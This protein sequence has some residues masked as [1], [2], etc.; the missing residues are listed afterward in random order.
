M[1]LTSSLWCCPWPFYCSS[2]WVLGP[3]SHPS[4]WSWEH[5]ELEELWGWS[6]EQEPCRLHSRLCWFPPHLL[7]LWELCCWWWSL[8]SLSL[9]N[10]SSQRS[11]WKVSLSSATM[12][13]SRPLALHSWLSLDVPQEKR[14]IW[15]CLTCQGRSQSI[16]SAYHTKLTR[17]CYWM[18]AYAISVVTNTWL[19]SSSSCTKSLSHRSSWTYSLPSSLMSSWRRMIYLAWSQIRG[20][21]PNS[22]TIGPSMIL[23]QQGSSLWKTSICSY[24]TWQMI[25]QPWVC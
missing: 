11:R 17:S 4:A 6:R 16:S 12:W 19:Q 24:L 9:G 1:S 15:S 20:R 2:Q 23:M 13:T 22:Y 25:R 8:C 14:G 5:S 10:L 21:F 3:I 18:E 7:D